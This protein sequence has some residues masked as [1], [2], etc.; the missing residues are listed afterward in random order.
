MIGEEEKTELELALKKIDGLKNDKKFVEE[1]ITDAKENIRKK[2]LKKFNDDKILS[3]GKF[4]MVGSDIRGNIREF[5]GYLDVY[6]ALCTTGHSDIYLTIED[7]DEAYGVHTEVRLA[8]APN[9]ITMYIGSDVRLEKM[10]KIVHK[11]GIQ[12]DIAGLDKSIAEY[13]RKHT[14]G[15]NNDLKLR[16]LLIMSGAVV[17]TPLSKMKGFED[18]LEKEE[19]YARLL[20]VTHKDVVEMVKKKDPGVRLTP[21]VIILTQ[22]FDL[23]ESNG[24]ILFFMMGRA[25]LE[26]VNKE[27]G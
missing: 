8:H 22:P 9:Y 7:D 15:N 3:G 11:Y 17:N 21:D 24:K 23:L 25:I 27:F 14:Y 16:N 12:I 26:Q 4:R 1:M 13:K 2:A 10:R 5:P 20:H 19:E 18:Y 6:T